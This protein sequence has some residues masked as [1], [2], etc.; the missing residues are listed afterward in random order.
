MIG[1][2]IVLNYHLLKHILFVPFVMQRSLNM[3]KSLCSTIEL[4]RLTDYCWRDYTHKGCII[5]LGPWLGGSTKALLNGLNSNDLVTI[6]D[7]FIWEEWMSGFTEAPV[8]IDCSFLHV[9]LGNLDYDRRVTP[10]VWD[11][12]KP[13]L[14]KCPIELLVID[15]AKS[16]EAMSGLTRS[17]F[18]SLIEGACIFDQDFRHAVSVHIYQKVFYMYLKD[19]LIPFETCDSGVWFKVIKVIPEELIVNLWGRI[20]NETPIS[21]VTQAIIYFKDYL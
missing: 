12:C 4:Q 3:I 8:P 16:I 14:W 5:D 13:L 17:F 6:I 20:W 9:T 11:L 2:F 21:V 10:Y 18:P 19:Y 1:D 7:R 15:A